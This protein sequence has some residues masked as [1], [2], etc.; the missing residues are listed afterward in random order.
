LIR[1]IDETGSSDKRHGGG[2]KR[3]ARVPENIG[4][5]QELVLSQEDKPRTHRTVRQ[6]ARDTGLAK[7]SV[8]RI[9][10]HDLKLKCFKKKKAQ[11]LSETSK[12]WT[13]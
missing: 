2:R 10:R 6:V 11:H 5:V 4:A 13:L 1:Q 12:W 8:N 3:S 9:I 7:S